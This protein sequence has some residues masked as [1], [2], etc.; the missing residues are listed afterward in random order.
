MLSGVDLCLHSG[1]GGTDRAQT[2]DGIAESNPPSP[3]A[4]WYVDER[5]NRKTED[6]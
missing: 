6:H 2:Q 1:Q 3:G 4:Q 5:L